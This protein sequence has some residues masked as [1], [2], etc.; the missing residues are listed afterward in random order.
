MDEVIDQVAIDSVLR[1]MVVFKTEASLKNT[2]YF[3]S[4]I[5]NA[6]EKS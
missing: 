6:G 1:Q 3:L 2:I 5:D 4:V